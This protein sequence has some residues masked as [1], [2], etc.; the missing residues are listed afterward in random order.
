MKNILHPIF[1]P[2]VHVPFGHKM[3]IAGFWIICFLFVWSN[4]PVLLPSPTAVGTQLVDFFTDAEFYSDLLSSLT[5]TIEAMIMS[6]VIASLIAYLSTI[7]F[8]RGLVQTLVKFRYM[9]LMGFFFAFMLMFHNGG[10]VKI[11]LLMWGIIPFFAL[12]ITSVISRIQQKEYD[13]WT[14]LR[15]TKWEQV[16][17]IIVYGKLDYLFE[18]VRANFAMGW[19]MITMVES[20]SMADG[21]L[22]VLLFKYNKY[23]QIDK[24]FALQ[25]VIFAIGTLFDYTLQQARYACFPHVALA[26]KN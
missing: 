6:I 4:A 5:L 24:I 2:F 16:Y 17:E 7:G 25:I 22:G 26:E 10:T 15:Y 13:L 14:T 18:A 23:N 19:L 11:I 8:M 21:G 12:S 20:F 3:A 9:S 1:T